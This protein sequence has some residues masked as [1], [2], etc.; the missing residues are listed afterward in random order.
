MEQNN[1][2]CYMIKTF[3][4]DDI[5]NYYKLEKDKIDLNFNNELPFITCCEYNKLET[6]KW[7]IKECNGD[8]NIDEGFFV[9][10]KNNNLEMAKYLWKNNRMTISNNYFIRLCKFE[11]LDVLGWIWNLVCNKEIYLSEHVLEESFKT[12]CAFN[13]IVVIRWLNK[14]CS[15]N[16]III[17]KEDLDDIFNKAC[18]IKNTETA[19]W[20]IDHYARFRGAVI[21][22]NIIWYNITDT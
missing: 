19:K 14:I 3:K 13:N 12:A 7:L 6:C 15:L 16:N 18:E 8:I 21:N 4:C 17:K 2:L 5:K 22:N 1:R 10:C 11:C 9:C 20:F